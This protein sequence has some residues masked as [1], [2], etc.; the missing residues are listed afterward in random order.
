[1]TR[2]L[3]AVPA[4]TAALLVATAVPAH[5]A[6]PYCHV[7][8]VAADAGQSASCV[9]PD[10]NENGLVLRRL[11]VHV[12]AG[13]VTATVTCG[14]RTGSI[15]VAAPFADSVTVIQPRFSSCTHTL[16][17]NAALTTAVGVS[18]YTVTHVGA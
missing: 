7:R 18:T 1:M 5:A 15:T 11:D 2:S 17:S 3:V 14:S 9:T 10:P 8:L 4:A 6:V 16:T 13:S 12:T